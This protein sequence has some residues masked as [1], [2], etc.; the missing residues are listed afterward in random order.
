[1]AKD[2][3]KQIAQSLY[4]DQCMTAKEIA[5]KLK[6]TEKTVGRWVEAG[7]WKEIRLSKQ[8][9]TET[10]LSKYNELLSSLLDKRLKY[11]KKKDQTD[12]DK[13]DYKGIIDEMSKISAM[14]DR[15]QKDG[16]SS[17]RV[18]I[19]CIEK[20][21]SALQN[22]QPKLFMQLLDFQIEYLQILA[23]ELK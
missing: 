9:T 6:L 17:L 14:I 8:T 13:E 15:L 11:E 10:L 7:N 2:N 21:M 5:S 3:E 18:H 20:F 22:A 19:M 1:M 4:V 23:E 16:R 12:E